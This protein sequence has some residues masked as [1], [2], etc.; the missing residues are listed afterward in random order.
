[1]FLDDHIYT[2]FTNYKTFHFMRSYSD[3]GSLTVQV[4]NWLENPQR[5]TR[6]KVQHSNSFKLIGIDLVLYCK[7]Q[8]IKKTHEKT[9]KT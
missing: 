1:M 2:I 8:H 7:L 9:T 4:E 5:I 6:L 3:S